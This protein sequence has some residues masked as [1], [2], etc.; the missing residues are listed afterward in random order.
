MQEDCSWLFGLSDFGFSFKMKI[1]QE[2]DPVTE[3]DWGNRLAEEPEFSIK[4]TEKYLV[5]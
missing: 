2:L 4:K 5:H 3:E 1:L